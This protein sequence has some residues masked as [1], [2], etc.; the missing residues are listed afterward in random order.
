M[1]VLHATSQPGRRLRTQDWHR[2][3]TRWSQITLVEN[4]PGNYDPQAWIDI[5]RSTRSNAACISAGGYIAYYPSTIPYH[6][7][8]RSLG[9]SDPFGEL[10]DGARALDMHV[11]ARI[12][13]HAIHNDAA[14]DNPGWVAVDSSGNP[15]RH[16][17][18]PEAWVTCAYGAYN[19]TYIPEIIREI[20]RDY[21]IDAIFANRWQ[22]HGVCYCASC[23]KR[24][25]EATGHDL[26]RGSKPEDPRWRAWQNWRRG[27]LST[28]I[29][30]WD[31]VVRDQ[32]AHASF[33][34][35]MGSASILEFD[36]DLIREHSPFLAVDNQ[37]RHD[38]Q[39]L[40]QAGRNGKRTR[41]I[42]RDRPSI[43]ITSVGPE[44]KSNRWKDSVNTAAELRG[45]IHNGTVQGM[46]PWFTKFNGMI[47]DPRWIDPVNEAFGRHEEIEAE[48]AETEPDAE[49]AILD[50]STTL[51]QFARDDW[52]R[53][54]A[55]ELGFYHALTEAK[56]PFE[57]VSDLALEDS[58]LDRI[59]VLVL[60]NVLNLSDAQCA[61]IAAWVARGGSLIAAAETSLYTEE[62]QPRLNFG[63]A[64]VLGVRLS[65]APRGPVK[66]TYVAMGGA[67]PLH[68]GYGE[69]QRFIGGTRLVGVIAAEGTQAPF[70][71]V[72]DFPDLPM[73]EVY[74]RAAA[75]EPSVVTRQTPAG[76]RVAYVAWNLGAV[77]WDAMAQ[78]HQRLIENLVRWALGRPQKVEVSGRSVLDIALRTGADKTVV[79]MANLTNPMMMK[80]PLREV[81]PVG[82]QVISAEV[83][84]GRSRCTARSLVGRQPLS[85]EYRDGRA[86]VR[87]PR[88]DEL[89]V[90]VFDWS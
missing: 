19:A 9:G 35:N 51:R 71:R 28:L 65:G 36:L 45:W 74:P 8:S 46:V 22:G 87:V 48:F 62:G 73:E 40:W 25:R 76:G 34:P 56:I 80:G 7:V 77:F 82:E 12:D 68:Q 32:R 54:Q 1:P 81:Y 30:E 42:F 64:D 55:D 37:G 60:P 3:A 53:V 39:A 41:A 24:F 11:M 75:T 2:S 43:L 85:A 67:H 31:K 21:D 14:R 88:I 61:A 33:I 10:V 90:V 27:I 57:Y 50:G 38:V 6:Y 89:E 83:P 5:F 17:A 86:T 63:L 78:D 18:Y 4:D 13:P 69:A 29:V 16:W 52:G 84:A 79:A 66:N 20:T 26:P 15:Q 58:F 49:V 59:K 23:S 72:P 47:P 44:H 70:L